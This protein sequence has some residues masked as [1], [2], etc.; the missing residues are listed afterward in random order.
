MNDT[1]TVVTDDELAAAFGGSNFGDR[2]HRELLENSVLKK[3]IGY[4][5][6]H[7]ITEIMKHLGLIGINE[8][9]TKKGKRLLQTAYSR[10]IMSKGG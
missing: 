6:G 8:T 1:R 7:T 10:L 9:I 4:H 3:A 2:D 5:C